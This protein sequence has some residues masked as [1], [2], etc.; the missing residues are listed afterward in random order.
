MPTHICRPLTSSAIASVMMAMRKYAGAHLSGATHDAGML[1]RY[2][3]SNVTEG[4]RPAATIRTKRAAVAWRENETDSSALGAVE[5]VG[6]ITLVRVRKAFGATRAPK[7]L[8]L[9]TES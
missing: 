5:S 1:S 2:C 3:V 7:N 4:E 6:G 8:V 9:T